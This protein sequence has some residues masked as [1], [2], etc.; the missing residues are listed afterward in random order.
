[1]EPLLSSGTECLRCYL[2]HPLIFWMRKL[3]MRDAK[4]FTWKHT[5]RSLLIMNWLGGHHKRWSPPFLQRMTRPA[6]LW[7]YVH[8]LVPAWT[9]SSLQT[10]LHHPPGRNKLFQH[11][12]LLWK[13]TCRG[14]PQAARMLLIDLHTLKSDLPGGSPILQSDGAW[15]FLSGCNVE[16]FDFGKEL[17]CI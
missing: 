5:G 16:A 11:G 4:V 13:Y 2:I 17:H 6:I 8:I 9:G 15:V 1:M 3:R 12:G 14:L 10:V 7:G